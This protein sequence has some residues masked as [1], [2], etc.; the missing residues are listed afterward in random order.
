MNFIEKHCYRWFATTQT[1]SLG[2]QYQ[3]QIGKRAGVNSSAAELRGGRYPNLL[4]LRSYLALLTF[5]VA[6][7]DQLDHLY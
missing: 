1:R 3:Q 2:W 4:L 7:V 6:T 5:G